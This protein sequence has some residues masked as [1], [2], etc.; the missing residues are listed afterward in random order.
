MPRLS[1]WFI[2][3]ALLHLATSVTLGGLILAAKGLPIAMGW[4][5]LLLPAHMQLALGG[6]LIQ[7]ALGMAYWVLPRLNGAGDR[8]RF[9]W[10]WA[11]FGL[12]NTGIV[13]A[14]LALALRPLARSIGLDLLLAFGAVLQLGGLAAFA[15]HTWPRLRPIVNDQP[16]EGRRA[17]A[18]T[19]Q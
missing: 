9:V 4:A 19:A 11:S 3:A 5:W 8:G 13:S 7:L 12:W 6:W 14:A 1:C 15:W 2:K 17:A 18:Q 16:A 10:A